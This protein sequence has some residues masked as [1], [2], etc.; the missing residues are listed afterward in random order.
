MTELREGEDVVEI[1]KNS[2]TEIIV[3][4]KNNQKPVELTVKEK[5]SNINKEIKRESESKIT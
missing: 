4:F 2:T 3:D 5:N 1:T